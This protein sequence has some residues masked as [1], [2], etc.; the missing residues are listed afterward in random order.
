[1]KKG[2]R[3]DEKGREESS[4]KERMMREIDERAR[5]GMKE[6]GRRVGAEDRL[7]LLP[8]LP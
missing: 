8:P 1:M 7:Q 4:V 5:R 3:R 2:V 6:E